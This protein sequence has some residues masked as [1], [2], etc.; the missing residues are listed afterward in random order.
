MDQVG[1]AWLKKNGVTADVVAGILKDAMDDYVLTKDRAMQ[2]LIKRRGGEAFECRVCS[3]LVSFGKVGAQP[4]HIDCVYPDFLGAMQL[5]PG[6]RTLLYPVH[7][8]IGVQHG[9]MTCRDFARLVRMRLGNWIKE[10]EEAALAEACEDNRVVR[11]SIQQFG[12]LLA[13]PDDRSHAN[14]RL[15]ASNPL[16]EDTRPGYMGMLGSICHCGPPCEEDRVVEFSAYAEKDAE[17]YTGNTQHNV[18]SFLGHTVIAL[19]PKAQAASNIVL[20]LYTEVLKDNPSLGRYL[21]DVV[22]EKS[23]KRKTEALEMLR[24]LSQIYRG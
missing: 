18:V 10:G 21:G 15:L 6:P 3:L 12:Y 4:I 8:E 9:E 2:A 13:S 5:T 24:T 22:V 19:A 17:G 11:E 16:L 7:E 1:G 20:R 14:E 23:E